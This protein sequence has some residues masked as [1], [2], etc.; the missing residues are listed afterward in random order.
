M[1][2]VGLVRV[3]LV[4]VGL[5]WFDLVFILLKNYE[6]DSINIGVY[7]IKKLYSLVFFGGI[8]VKNEDNG[9]GCL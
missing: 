2:F 9:P 6:S 7:I 3:G 8:S 1:S 4:R 5:V